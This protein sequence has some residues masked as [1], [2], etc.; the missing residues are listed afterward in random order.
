MTKTEKDQYHS[1]E[2]LRAMIEKLKGKKFE[3][4]CGH[5]V[6]LCHS[7]GNNVLMINGRHP[8]IICSLCGY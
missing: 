7:L 8:T 2:E 1:A 4:D 6:T 5:H 3:L